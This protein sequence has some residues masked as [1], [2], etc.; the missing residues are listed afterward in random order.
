MGNHERALTLLANELRDAA[1]AEA[2]CA[3]G[4][5]VVPARAA[6]ALGDAHGLQAWAALLA[7]ASGPGA[8]GAPAISRQ[9]TVDEGVR[10]ALVKVL[11]GVYM[12]GGCVHTLAM[13]IGTDPTVAQGSE[14][15]AHG[16]TA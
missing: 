15:G 3:L 9:S 16:S 5:A 10:R 14:R 1:S 13:D 11:L 7:P 12:N 2:Y 8:R 6:A 4:G